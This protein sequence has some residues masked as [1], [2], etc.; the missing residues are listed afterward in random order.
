MLPFTRFNRN[1]RTIRRYRTILGIL[2]KYGF[3]QFVE[4]LNIN[5]Y[6]ELG[7]KIVTLGTAPKGI[8]RLGQPQRLRLAL[9]EL[10]PTFIKLGQLLSTRPDLIP[11]DYLDELKKLQD[12]VPSVPT[13]QIRIEI[14]SE[15]GY[16]LAELF[17]H[18]DPEPVAAASVAQV[19]RG[20]LH[21]GEEVVFKIRRPGIAQVIE[22]DLDILMGLAYLVEHHL[23]GGDIY[24]P[25][26]LVKEFRRTIHRELDFTREARTIERFAANF[27]GDDSVH[28]PKVHW[29][30]CGERVLTMEYISGIKVN[31][32][33]RLRAE[34]YDL[35]LIA[36]RGANS[37]LRQVL[38]FGFFHGDPHPGNIFILPGDTICMLDYGMVGRINQDL[39]EQLVDLL[40]A[41]LQ[42]DVDRI[43]S[44]LLYSG[45]LTDE[46]NLKALNR[47]L[48]EFIEDYYEIPLQDIKVGKLLAD[49]VEI[50]THYRIRF[51]SDLMLLA[52]ALV[53]M[54]GL[55]RQL[56][57]DFNMITH[58]RPF[59]ERLV[60]ERLTPTNLS[61]EMLRVAQAYGSLA[62]HLPRDIKEFINRVNRN[63]FKIDL[64]HRGLE[65]LITDL[66][67]AS[68]RLSFS[69]LIAALI[70]GSSLI[71]QTEKGPMIFGF[72]A[73]GFLG[74]SVA[75][76]LGLWLAIAIL[77]SGRL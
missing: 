47:D 2:I 4:Q 70:I 53:A 9:E 18:F 48:G 5:Y 33:E 61:R 21:S 67:K 39:K 42:R 20:R 32:L 68:N 46:S 63:K 29:D 59:L 24:D 6:L 23:P 58:L 14:E 36:D 15:L 1:I 51:P 75:G 16:P 43:I 74:Y 17:A 73:L 45:E 60:K 55:G 31:D 7:R 41:V 72:P 49:F 19:H 52:R 76:F 38:E 28:V 57:P 34:D 3:G 66:D 26:G 71:M 30:F 77:R 64:E 69:L 62:R 13:E 8:E 37:F 44:Q 50:L 25:V 54:E 65:K 10:G 27:E 40:L 56:D 11:G 12:K 35:K 22:T